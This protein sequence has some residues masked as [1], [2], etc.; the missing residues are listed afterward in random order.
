MPIPCP[1]LEP[2]CELMT[3]DDFNSNWKSIGEEEYCASDCFYERR[4][5][6]R[7]RYFDEFIV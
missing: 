4:E 5:N 7:S 6:S 3:L 2:I 1:L